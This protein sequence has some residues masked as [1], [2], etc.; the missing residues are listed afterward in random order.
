MTPAE[1]KD[2]TRQFA[3][4]VIHLSQALAK[5]READVIARQLVRSATSVAANY[6][7]ACRARSSREFVAK[8]AIV[9]EEADE[10]MLWM[11]LLI[12]G[13]MVK[14]VRLGDLLSEANELVAIVVASR[15]TARRSAKSKIHNRKS[16]IDNV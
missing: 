5:S 1:L 13:G 10:S 4:R 16:E 14:A 11:E 15:K 9:E 2:R 7:A 12:A 3:L 6:R 8:M